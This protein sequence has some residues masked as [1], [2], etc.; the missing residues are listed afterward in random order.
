M[1]TYT[2]QNNYINRHILQQL[3]STN[4][5]CE[6]LVKPKQGHLPEDTKIGILVSLYYDFL[7]DYEMIRTG[8]K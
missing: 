5:A 2:S 4:H 8:F 1:P 6:N 7:Y 3:F